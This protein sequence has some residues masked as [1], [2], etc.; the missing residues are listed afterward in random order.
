MNK[1]QDQLIVAKGL[2]RTFRMGNVDV[3]ALNQVSF[4]IPRGSF[5]AIIGPS[6]SGK[7]TLLNLLGLVDH[8]SSGELYINDIP[9]HKQSD[10]QQTKLRA[11]HIGFIFQSFHLIP[12]LNVLDNV[13]LQLHFSDIPPKDRKDLAIQALQEVGL[14]NRMHYYPNDLSG[15]QRQRV[16][17]ARAIA[18]RPDIILADE[19]TG[20]LD[21]KTGEE[22]MSI[23]NELHRSGKT[24]I[25]VTHDLEIAARAERQLIM[26]DGQISET[27]S[28]Q[29]SELKKVY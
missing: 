9:V 21:S 17:I 6:G 22:I 14:G 5:T 16:S 3:Q 12:V 23:I 19:P 15:G 18:K 13:I 7:S 28:N 11:K 4:E 2:S 25:M 8:P 1:I 20:S 10:S 27:R 29:I 26:R 24:I